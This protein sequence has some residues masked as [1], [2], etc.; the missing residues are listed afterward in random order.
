MIKLT[1]QVTSF[2]ENLFAIGPVLAYQTTRVIEP[3]K[4]V[5]FKMP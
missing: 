1:L 3:K 4:S 2:S 5:E